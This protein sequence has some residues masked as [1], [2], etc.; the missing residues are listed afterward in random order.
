LNFTLPVSDNALTSISQRT[1]TAAMTQILSFPLRRPLTI[2]RSPALRLL[3][4]LVLIL[5]SAAVVWST[6][7]SAGSFCFTTGG[8]QPPRR[9]SSAH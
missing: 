1:G 7:I 3:A 8:A 4:A 2:R 9:L 6:I 5:F